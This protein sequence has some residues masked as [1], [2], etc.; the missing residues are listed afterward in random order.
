MEPAAARARVDDDRPARRGLHD[1][2]RI[3]TGGARTVL[4][5]QQTLLARSPGASTALTDVERAVFRRLAVFHAPFPL[6]AAESRR[7]RRIDESP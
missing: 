1:A 7:R 6:D 5:R 4:P 3:L 2:F